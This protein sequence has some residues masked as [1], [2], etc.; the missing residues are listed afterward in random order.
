[1]FLSQSEISFL[2]P[3][4]LFVLIIAVNQNTHKAVGAILDSSPSSTSTRKTL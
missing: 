3:I 2:E 1:M 4:R